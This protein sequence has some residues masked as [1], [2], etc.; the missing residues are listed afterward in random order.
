M[1]QSVLGTTDK[2]QLR[3]SHSR[4]MTHAIPLNQLSTY[5]KK[6]QWKEFTHC[7]APWPMTRQFLPWS[8]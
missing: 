2:T 8:Q 1:V 4:K 7:F 5:V 6:M 3:F